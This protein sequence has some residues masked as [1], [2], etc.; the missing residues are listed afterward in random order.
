MNTGTVSGVVPRAEYRPG[1]VEECGALFAQLDRD[2]DAVVVLGNGTQRGFGAPP[3]RLDALVHT[4]ALDRVV[5]YAPADQIVSVEAG[6][7]LG[8]LRRLLAEHNQ[9]LAL[10]PPHAEH[11][12]LGGLSRRMPSARGAPATDRSRT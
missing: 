7:T 4:G 5:E 6:M 12:T 9:T 10:D 3:E 8:A 2:G 11:E 1:T